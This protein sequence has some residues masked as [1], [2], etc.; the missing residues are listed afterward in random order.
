MAPHEAY[1]DNPWL[2][3]DTPSRFTSPDDQPVAMA[4]MEDGERV[5]VIMS[6]RYGMF[7]LDYSHKR[8]DPIARRVKEGTLTEGDLTT[9]LH[10]EVDTAVLMDAILGP[11]I[12]IYNPQRES[13]V[14]N[15]LGEER[16]LQLKM[17]AALCNHIA[18]ECDV[19]LARRMIYLMLHTQEMGLWE[20]NPEPDSPKLRALDT[21]ARE[22]VGY[23]DQIAAI[24]APHP[25]RITQ[26]AVQAC[27]R[28]DVGECLHSYNI[29]S[30]ECTIGRNGG[31][32]ANV[33]SPTLAYDDAP[34]FQQ[35][36]PKDRE[37]S[38][39]NDPTHIFAYGTMPAIELEIIQDTPTHI[40]RVND[41]PMEI[42]QLHA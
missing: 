26:A 37:S 9:L 2:H 36:Y 5:I 33:I 7:M 41:F 29:T 4:N 25:E 21:F 27:S 28:V 13:F 40:S 10:P 6:A 24:F 35:R 11:G 32:V 30:G 3:I 23:D 20:L 18:K 42:T 39:A 34:T 15:Y 17:Y 8:F 38:A 19:T 12:A 14:I 16:S 22:F 31:V 1:A